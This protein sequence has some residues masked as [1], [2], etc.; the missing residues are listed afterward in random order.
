MVIVL[1]LIVTMTAGPKAPRV[2]VV[3]AHPEKIY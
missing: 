2:L 3:M 1:L